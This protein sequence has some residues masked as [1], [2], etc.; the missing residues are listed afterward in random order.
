MAA[1]ID[2]VTLRLVVAVMDTG[3]IAEAAEREHIAPSAVSK[4]L[5]D[6]ED[7]LNTVLVQR[8]NRGIEPTAAGLELLGLARNVLNDLDNIHLR[9]RDYASG[10]RGLV[11]VLSNLS[12]ITE[13]LPQCL[14]SFSTH[15]PNVQVQLQERIS[16]AVQQGVAS[17]AADVGIYAHGIGGV[18]GLVTMPFRCDE[19]VVVV[20]VD[21]ALAA[22]DA[23]RIVD[24]IAYDYV[25][26]HTGSYINQQ[27]LKAASE[28]EKPFRCR[29]QVT[30]FDALSLMVEAGMGIAVM[31]K[32]IGLRYSALARIK[33][34]ALDEAW[35][36][37]ELRI[38]VRSFDSL[39]VAAKLF[40]SHLSARQP[41]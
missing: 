38:C 1:R 25:G 5:S 24:T 18:E 35:A 20:P 34:L 11:R 22:R 23:V 39:S 16:S 9:L 28:C 7:S 32:A 21:H 27:I 19:L 30:S 41:Q 13:F 37:R 2:P 15:Y 10:A 4:R 17:N 3:T 29:V 8:T 36:R 31:P 26:L 6:L 12:A 14:H 33:V 40:V